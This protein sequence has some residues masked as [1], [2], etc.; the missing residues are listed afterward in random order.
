MNSITFPGRTFLSVPN[1][2]NEF[3]LCYFKFYKLKY[4]KQNFFPF[5]LIVFIFLIYFLLFQTSLRNI[6]GSS[7][8]FY[9]GSSG[10]IQRTIFGA[11]CNINPPLTWHELHHG[12]HGCQNIPLS[13]WL[14][15]KQYNSNIYKFQK[16]IRIYNNE[17]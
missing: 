12:Y 4:V 8:Q 15:T 2:Q 10:K 16:R 6:D 3:N 5:Y 14:Q 1:V 7:P 13:L 11:P 17:T 9:D